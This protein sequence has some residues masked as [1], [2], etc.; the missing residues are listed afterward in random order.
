[1]EFSVKRRINRIL[2]DVQRTQQLAGLSD[3]KQGYVAP[4]NAYQ[5]DY[6]GLQ[7]IFGNGIL[8]KLILFIKTQLNTPI[9][10]LKSDNQDLTI[11]VLNTQDVN[12]KQLNNGE[13]FVRFGGY[14]SDAKNYNFNIGYKSNLGQINFIYKFTMDLNGNIGNWQ[15]LN[16]NS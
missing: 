13:C 6:S 12:L 16:F 5:D 11:R 4:Q 7:K 2:E 15:S 8:N 9:V 10:L 3:P 14:M 1:M